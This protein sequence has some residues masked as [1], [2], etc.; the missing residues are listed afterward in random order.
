M[1]FLKKAK[2]KNAGKALF[3]IT[4][5]LGICH[6]MSSV[7]PLLCFVHQWKFDIVLPVRAN[8]MCYL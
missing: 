4:V 7:Y 2:N 5:I 1:F 6:K 3:N 8:V